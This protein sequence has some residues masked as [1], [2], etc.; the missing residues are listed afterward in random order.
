M[1]TPHGP[2]LHLVGTAMPASVNISAALRSAGTCSTWPL[3]VR[4]V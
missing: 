3:L 4:F 2:S 1:Q